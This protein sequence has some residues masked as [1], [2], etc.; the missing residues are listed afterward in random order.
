MIDKDAFGGSAGFEGL[1][2][3]LKKG[4]AGKPFP[5]LEDVEKSTKKE[6]A[7]WK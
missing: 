3:K 1:N 5:T 2:N 6:E 7:G 4:K